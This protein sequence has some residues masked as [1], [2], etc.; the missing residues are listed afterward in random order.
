MK[1]KRK[2]HSPKTFEGG[3]G[4][5]VDITFNGFRRAEI[6]RHPSAPAVVNI[7][8][9]RRLSLGW[10]KHGTPPNLLRCEL[11]ALGYREI[12]FHDL[13]GDAGYLAIFSPPWGVDR[14]Q[15]HAILPCKTEQ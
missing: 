9:L 4:R 15:P 14:P 2:C 11:A 1:K 10:Y 12:V 5:S 7:R 3:D 13:A 8:W 6:D